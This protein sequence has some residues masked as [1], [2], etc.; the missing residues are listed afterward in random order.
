MSVGS[1]K[2]QFEPLESYQFKAH[3]HTHTETHLEKGY[4]RVAGRLGTNGL[5]RLT[6]ENNLNFKLRK[7]KQIQ[8]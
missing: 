2:L 5:E 3:S 7:A 6:V 1:L 4:Q 8:K